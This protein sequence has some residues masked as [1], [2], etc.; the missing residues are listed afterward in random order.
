MPTIMAILGQTS[1]TMAMT[2][3]RI[4]DP[5]VL[6]DYQAVLGP[7]TALAGPAAEA[8]RSGALTESAVQ[9]LATNFL[10]TELELGHCLRLPQE[11]P[12]QC[13]LY[14]T[15]AKFVTTNAYAPRL[16]QRRAL[17]LSL[18]ADAE[19]GAGSVKSTVT[20]ASSAVLTR[21]WASSV[22]QSRK[23]RRFTRAYDPSKTTQT[24]RLRTRRIDNAPDASG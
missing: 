19:S 16:R 24:L 2:Y 21:C 6:A 9:W 17:E 7:G 10:K 20:S 5:V 14:L 13:D 23:K 12:C 15:C 11:G 4:S 22:S 1:A 8:V 3:S 18:A